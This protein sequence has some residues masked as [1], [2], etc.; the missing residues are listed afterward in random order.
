MGRL[1]GRGV[2]RRGA[3]A[4]KSRR[5]LGP[6]ERHVQGDEVR[7]PYRRCSLYSGRKVR[8]L[9]VVSSKWSKEGED[10]RLVSHSSQVEALP[11]VKSEN[12]IYAM[13]VYK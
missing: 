10:Q 6:L 9:I 4:D 2:V 8:M 3:S 11:M 13:V 7:I 12:L 1:R 5:L